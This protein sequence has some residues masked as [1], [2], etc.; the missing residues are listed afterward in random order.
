MVLPRELKKVNTSKTL[1][2][3]KKKYLKMASSKSK[4]EDV[5]KLDTLCILVFRLG[6]ILTC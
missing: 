6:E 1:S 4:H 2:N 5:S 3:R